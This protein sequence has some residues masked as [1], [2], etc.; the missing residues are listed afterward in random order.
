MWIMNKLFSFIIIAATAFS[1]SNNQE[2]CVELNDTRLVGD[3]KLQNG[4]SVK[5][6]NA[7]PYFTTFP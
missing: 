4:F 7:D 1:C 3:W 2:A 6:R 5:P